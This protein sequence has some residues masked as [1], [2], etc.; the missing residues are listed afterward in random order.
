ME[1][2]RIVEPDDANAHTFADNLTSIYG[3]F[4]HNGSGRS[5]GCVHRTCQDLVELESPSF[6]P[7]DS[8]HYVLKTAEKFYL[9]S[10]RKNFVAI[11]L[12]RS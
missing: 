4:A 2:I 6:Q 10:L 1:V 8:F 12:S 9:Y 11:K 3:H 5:N 7:I